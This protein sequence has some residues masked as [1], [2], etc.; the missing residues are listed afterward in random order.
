MYSYELFAEACCLAGLI[1]KE[2]AR[3]TVY[4]KGQV[5]W[6]VFGLCV[7]SLMNEVQG[8]MTEGEGGFRNH[9]ILYDVIY[10]WSLT[11]SWSWWFFSLLLLG[12][13]QATVLTGV[14]L[15]DGVHT[16]H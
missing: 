10:E 16:V 13:D 6:L 12:W 7:T 9:P 5:F 11:F 14:H 4:F 15:G 2:F 3:K 1:E 8:I